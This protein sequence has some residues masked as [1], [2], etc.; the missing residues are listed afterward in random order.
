MAL[1]VEDG[2]QVVNSDSY[3][4]STDIESFL[5]ERSILSET[6]ATQAQRESMA[7]RAMDYLNTMDY[8]GKR[9]SDTQSLAFPRSGITLSDNRLL[10]PDAIPSELKQAQMWLIYYI[11]NGSDPTATQTQL[12]KR[13]K[14]DTLEIE[15]QDGSSFNS[16]SINSLPN[17]K[18]LLK[19]LVSSTN[20]LDRA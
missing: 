5:S 9:V 7:L 4:N 8:L 17:V 14:V 10:E 20:Y 13:E 12:V 15:Y 18:N 16:T 3:V 2:S 1:I 19:H 11:D 6:L